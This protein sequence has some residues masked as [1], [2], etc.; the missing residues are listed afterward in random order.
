MN[1]ANF[2]FGY[3]AITMIIVLVTTKEKS[4]GTN[5]NQENWMLVFRL[6]YHNQIQIISLKL[7]TSK[8]IASIDDVAMLGEAA[9]HVFHTL[10]QCIELGVDEHFGHQMIRGK[11]NQPLT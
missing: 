1:Q 7:L 4:L 2:L 8:S 10:L 9:K 11:L 6:M 5:F 3:E